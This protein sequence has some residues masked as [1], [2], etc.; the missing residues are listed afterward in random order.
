MKRKNRPSGQDGGSKWVPFGTEGS[1]GWGR[2]RRLGNYKGKKKE[3]DFS[4]LHEK[5][6]EAEA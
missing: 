3:R 1:S 6:T 2:I 4:H 5:F